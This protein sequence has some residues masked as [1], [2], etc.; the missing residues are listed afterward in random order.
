MSDAWKLSFETQFRRSVNVIELAANLM[1]MLCSFIVILFDDAGSVQNF[2][3]TFDCKYEVVPD[4]GI[5]SHA[6]T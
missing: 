4:A 5:E 6:R 1:Y 3:A 2:P